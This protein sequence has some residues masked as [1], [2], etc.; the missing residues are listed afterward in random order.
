LIILED[1]YSELYL[2]VCVLTYFV[3][4]HCHQLVRCGFSSVSMMD[5]E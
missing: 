5:D 2:Y 3:S 1:D 4:S